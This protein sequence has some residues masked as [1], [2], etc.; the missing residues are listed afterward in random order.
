MVQQARG[1]WRRPLE[2]L[3]AIAASAALVLVAAGCDDGDDDDAV[4]KSASG[5]VIVPVGGGVPPAPP[6]STPAITAVT[7]ASGASAGGNLL[8]I[9]GINFGTGAAVR[10]GT[11]PAAVISQTSTQLT[12]VLPPAPPGVSGPLDVSVTNPNTR[13]GSLAGGYTYLASAV[14]SGSGTLLALDCDIDDAG[15]VHVVWHAG[16]AG[17]DVETRYIRSADD[18]KTWSGETLLQR[19][20]NPASRPRVGAGGGSVMAVWN[21]QVGGVHQIT[22]ARSTDAGATWSGAARFQSTPLVMADADV[23]VDDNAL[24]LVAHRVSGGTSASG[25]ALTHV[26]VIAGTVGMAPATPVAVAGGTIAARAPVVAADGAGLVTV[27]WLAEGADGGGSRELWVT[28]SS[29]GGGSYLTP[30]QLTQAASSGWTP[31]DP[32]LAMSG[33]RAAIAFAQNGVDYAGR[34][35]TDVMVALSTDGGASWP[36]GGPVAGGVAGQSRFTPGA[37]VTPNGEV[38]IAWQESV[39]GGPG[40]EIRA[41]HTTN[42]GGSWAIV[43]RSGTAASSILPSVCGGASGNRVIHLWAEGAGVWSY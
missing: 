39:F 19:T 29:D 35:V 15:V 33:S 4:V 12:V 20:S 38:N 26:Q 41:A 16:L 18:G 28:S 37:A 32:S 42:G 3:G 8:Q 22:S 24:A 13:S 11:Q 40:F 21:E 14:S 7:P 5:P 2:A 23:D 36:G 25:N 17:G 30:L 43:N 34:A 1:A 9:A 6:G 31:A 10:I 27:A